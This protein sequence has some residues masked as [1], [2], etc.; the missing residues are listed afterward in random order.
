MGKEEVLSSFITSRP[1]VEIPFNSTL[2]PLPLLRIGE[3][4]PEEVQ[5]QSDLRGYHQWFV[6]GVIKWQKYVFLQSRTIIA[7][8]VQK[9]EF[10]S[11]PKSFGSASISSSAM[12]LT[13]MFRIVSKRFP[14]LFAR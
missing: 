6:G 11:N 14:S 7:K 4:L 2:A 5:L 1:F 8:E 12:E 9:E 13:Y 3:N 10:Q